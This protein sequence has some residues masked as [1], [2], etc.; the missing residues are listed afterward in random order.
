[1]PPP[2]DEPNQSPEGPRVLLSLLRADDLLALDFAFHNFTLDT[3]G[4]APSLVRVAGQP[5][6]IVVTFPPQHIAEIV[7]QQSDDGSLSGLARPPVPA[8]MALPSRLAFA[9]P[10]DVAAIPLNLAA[11]LAWTRFQQSVPANARPAALG[12][13]GGPAPAPPGPTET[14]I[15][16]PYRLILSP[17]DTAGWSHTTEAV[18]LDGRT[19]LWHTRLGVRNADGTVDETLLPPVC[20]VWAADLDGNLTSQPMAGTLASDERKA[21]ANGSAN[22][23]LMD[24]RLIG[25]FNQPVHIPFFTSPLETRHLMLSALGAWTDL[26]GRLESDGARVAADTDSGR[27]APRG[28]PGS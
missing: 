20:A 13:P 12:V 3:A 22:F 14:A 24:T 21:I 25:P 16:L 8:A 10:D 9:V 7:F 1:M 23:S 6:H 26:H 5:A 28:G 18:T 17:D 11:L 4:G 27:V 19:E 2:E 15:E